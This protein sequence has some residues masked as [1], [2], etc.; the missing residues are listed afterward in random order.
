M[1]RSQRHTLRAQFG[2]LQMLEGR[3]ID[4]RD[5][6]HMAELPTIG[7]A[8]PLAATNRTNVWRE[9]TSPPHGGLCD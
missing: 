6:D 8:Y 1:V 5:G 2:R 3:R 7:C 9:V 4:A